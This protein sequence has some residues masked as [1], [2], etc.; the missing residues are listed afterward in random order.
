MKFQN[1]NNRSYQATTNK[2]GADIPD[3]TSQ[4]NIEERILS[5]YGGISKQINERISLEAS[6]EAEQY[7]S[8]QWNKWHIYPTLNASWKPILATYSTYPSVPAHSFLAIGQL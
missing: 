7:H 5:F 6:V 2:D 1:S 4:V 3:A 8:P